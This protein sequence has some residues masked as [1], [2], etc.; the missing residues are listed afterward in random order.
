MIVPYSYPDYYKDRSKSK[1]SNAYAPLC[2]LSSIAAL[3]AYRNYHTSWLDPIYS[4]LSLS[5]IT[6]KRTNTEDCKSYDSSLFLY[7][8]PPITAIREIE[9][10]TLRSSLQQG[11]ASLHSPYSTSSALRRSSR[12]VIKVR[13]SILSSSPSSQIEWVIIHQLY[14]FS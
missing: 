5:F 1:N 6:F 12:E 9:K 7:L 13:L 3:F 2:S 8:L 4:F 10:K 11:G 14:P